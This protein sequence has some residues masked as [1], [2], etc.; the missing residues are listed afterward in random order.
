MGE[1]TMKKEVE[2]GDSTRASP[3]PHDDSKSAGEDDAATL[4][5]LSPDSAADANPDTDLAPLSVQLG[6][7]IEKRQRRLTI[8]LSC[9]DSKIDHAMSSHAGKC[10]SCEQHG[11]RTDVL[12]TP[13]EVKSP[14]MIRAEEIQSNLEP[15]FP[16][17]LKA[18][19]RSHVGSCFW[20]GLPGPFCR[21]NLPSEDTTVT[22]E[23]E[24]GK[25][26]NI[27]YIGYK[28]GLS[29]GW[30]QFCVAHNLLEGDALVFQLVGNCRFKVYIIRANDLAEV[31]GALDF[32][33]QKG[34][35]NTVMAIVPS[36]IAKK[37]RCK[38]P[39][40]SFL[41]KKKR[42]TSK[43]RSSFHDTTGQPPAEQSENDSEEVG[44]EVLE[45]FK[46]SFPGLK[47]KDIQSFEEFS[48]VI[49]GLVLDSE[50]TEDIRRKYYKLCCGQNAFLHED[51]IKGLNFKL[52]AGVISEIISIADAMRG[53]DLSTSRDEFATWDKTLKA[54][55]LF[56]MNVAFLRARLTRLV[57]L[58]FDSEDAAKTRRYVE[59]RT[60]RLHIEDEIRNLE[61]KLVGLKATHERYGSDVENLKTRAE[62]YEVKFNREVLSPW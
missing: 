21:A 41:R 32:M 1:T 23:D 7:P 43:P 24:D 52:V 34:H 22:L 29:A 60:G 54:S 37:R 61:A 18:L 9:S 17:F 5:S 15:E 53:C 50:L 33:E 25:E 62:R 59:A 46:L 45:G 49:E 57:T 47:F 13:K 27:K 8:K 3:M 10:I 58:A 26:F 19:V 14:A 56:G 39:Q 20:M 12:S 6:N 48:I 55:E 16:S 2:D 44:S 40:S 4:L 28:T 31:D 35:V 51:L 38:A 42:K 11:T 30:R 36:K